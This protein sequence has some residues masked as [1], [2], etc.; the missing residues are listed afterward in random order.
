MSGDRESAPVA[1]NAVTGVTWMWEARAAPGRG[2][3]LVAW[4]LGA[5]GDRRGAGRA[6]VYRGRGDGADLVVVV[7]HLDP[8]AGEV[9]PDAVLSRPPSGLLARPPQAW[10]FER[11]SR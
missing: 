3:E 1:V 6:E 7:L 2:G 9:P 10:D 11:V 8:G 4:A 5:T